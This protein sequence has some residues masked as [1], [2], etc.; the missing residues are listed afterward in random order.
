MK[1]FLGFVCAIA[2][3]CLAVGCGDDKSPAK[4]PAK[5]PEKTPP[6]GTSQTEPGPGASADSEQQP[7]PQQ[8]IEPAPENV[9]PEKAGQPEGTDPEAAQPAPGGTQTPEKQ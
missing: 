5:S 8:P 2:I 9:A 7:A 4:S 6:A 3:A 1:Q